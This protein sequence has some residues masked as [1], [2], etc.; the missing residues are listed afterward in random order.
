MQIK[1]ED[2]LHVL[3]RKICFELFGVGMI[4][5]YITETKEGRS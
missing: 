1:K 4:R 3:I 5:L 2:E